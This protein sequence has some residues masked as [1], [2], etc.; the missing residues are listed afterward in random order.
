M[1]SRTILISEQPSLH[2]VWYQS[3]IYI[4]PLPRFLLDWSFWNHWICTVEKKDGETE[5][6]WKEAN[7]FVLTYTYL[8]VHESDFRIAQELGLLTPEI[9]WSQR[10][11]LRRDI[12]S[13]LKFVDGSVDLSKVTHRYHYGELRLS[14]LNHVYRFFRFRLLGYHHVYRNYNSFFS[15]EFAWLLLL[16]AYV[17]VAMTAFQTAVAFGDVPQALE[18]VGYWF[19]VAILFLIGIGSAIQIGLLAVLFVFNF[20]RT[21]TSKG[22]A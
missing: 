17:T 7:G 6:L 2:L 3:A 1:M 10:S 14:R 11:S 12:T 21:L 19:G 15:Q 20:I 9:T 13:A 8:M 18:R 4:K 16:F 22:T 5:V